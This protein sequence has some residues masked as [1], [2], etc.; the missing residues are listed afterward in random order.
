MNK[1]NYD[2]TMTELL[3]SLQEKPRLYLHSCCAPCSTRCLEELAEYFD[4]T[5]VYYNPNID[6]DEEY[7]LRLAEQIRYIEEVYGKSISVI[8]EG[9]KKADFDAIACGKENIPEGGARCFECYR[10][11][12][13]KAASYCRPD[14]YFA[15]TLTVSPL[16]NADKI[17]EIG[18]FLAQKYGVKYLPSDFKK[19]EGYKRSIVLAAEH[20]LYRQNYCGCEFSKRQN[21]K[22]GLEKP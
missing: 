13:D 21:T 3:D 2:K 11:R 7:S 4:I 17:N 10:L 6:T 5:V 18:F 14:D 8:D 12:L 20:G 1:Q 22:N 15:T 16:K 19:R 9:H